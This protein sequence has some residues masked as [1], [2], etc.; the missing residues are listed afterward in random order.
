M[1]ISRYEA[2]TMADSA[3]VYIYGLGPTTSS[4]EIRNAFEVYGPIVSVFISRNPS[5]CAFVVYVNQRDA[6]RAVHEMNG[7][8]VWGVMI[9]VELV[10]L[11][12]PRRRRSRSQLHVWYPPWVPPI[13]YSPP[14]VPACM[15]PPLFSRPRAPMQNGHETSP[16][17]FP[18]RRGAS[19]S[20]LRYPVRRD[21]PRSPLRFPV[22]RGRSGSPGRSPL[23]RNRRSPR[24]HPRRRDR[25]RSPHHGFERIRSR[26]P[27]PRSRSWQHGRSDTSRPPS[28]DDHGRRSSFARR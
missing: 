4:A 18:M 20:P 7:S 17:R 10:L 1:D 9:R 2:P 14:P 22:R 13:F 15:N 5:G 16:R 6:E 28:P 11:Q 25:S 23:R 21:P 26:S 12:R 3:R 24:Y 27:L 8:T 19:R